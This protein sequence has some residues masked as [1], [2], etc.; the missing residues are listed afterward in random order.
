MGIRNQNNNNN[1]KPLGHTVNI[2]LATNF[3]EW[4][5]SQQVVAILLEGIG[6]GS[7]APWGVWCPSLIVFAPW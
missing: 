7:A 2:R 4:K 6:A 3:T 1:N 5:T